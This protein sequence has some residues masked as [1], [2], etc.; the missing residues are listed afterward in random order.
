TDY[1]QFR[2]NPNGWIG[3]GDDNEEWQNTAIP[4]SDAPRPAILAFWDDLRPFDGSEGEG[5]VYYYSTPDSLVVWFDHVIH[6]V[7]TYSG[8]YDFEII[9][10]PN[11]EILTQ[12]RTVS[13]DIDTATIGIQNE[14][15]DIGL[16]VVFNDDYV[17]DELAILFKKVDV[18]LDLSENNGTIESGQSEFITLTANSE[19]FEPGDYLCNLLIASNDEIQS[20]ITVPV[21]LHLESANSDDEEIPLVTKLKG[22]FPNPFNPST[23][24]S[25]STAES[26]ELTEMVIYNLKGQKVKTLVNE[27]LDAGTHQ[28]VWNGKDNSGKNVSSGVYFYRLKSGKY[29]STKKMILMK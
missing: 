3:F 28:V 21:N 23:T 4:S 25:F 11:G 1:D 14:E 13:G 20:V 19:G 12:Y 24:I 22:N 9:I 7:G 16:Q 17:E 18:W 27:K 10:Y 29:T 15:G 26:T 2:I 5:Y 6:Y 8:T